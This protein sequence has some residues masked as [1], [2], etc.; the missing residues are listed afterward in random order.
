MNNPIYAALGLHSF[1]TSAVIQTSRK[2]N[3][4]QGFKPTLLLAL[5]FYSFMQKALNSETSGV[6]EVNGIVLSNDVNFYNV[7][8]ID[9][10]SLGNV[11][12]TIRYLKGKYQ[13]TEI[14]ETLSD[15]L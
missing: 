11:R 13:G 14:C 2:Q 5:C 6:K 3:R 9:F 10:F 1:G 7:K 15:Y 8:M 12:T 4:L